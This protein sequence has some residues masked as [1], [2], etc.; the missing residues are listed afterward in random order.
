MALNSASRGR[1]RSLPQPSLRTV[2]SLP[3][4]QQ[5]PVVQDARPLPPANPPSP[6]VM[7]EQK[8]LSRQISTPVM[9]SRTGRPLPT[10]LERSS[11]LQSIRE[12]HTPP[13]VSSPSPTPQ[14]PSVVNADYGVRWSSSAPIID[15]SDTISSVK[16]LD[17]YILSHPSPQHQHPPRLTSTTS[18]NV[19]GRPLPPPPGP[20]GSAAM[21]PS[22]SLDRGVLRS[23]LGM[24]AGTGEGRLG[25][26]G[27]ERKGDDERRNDGD[28][29][30]PSEEGSISPTTRKDSQAVPVID[31]PAPS[32]HDTPVEPPH[33]NHSQVHQ[34]STPTAPHTTPQISVSPVQP[35]NDSKAP[36]IPTIA[37]PDSA[38]ACDTST[39]IPRNRCPLPVPP[40]SPS[41]GMPSIAIDVSGDDDGAGSYVPTISVSPEGNNSTAPSIAIPVIAF[42]DETDSVAQNLFLRGYP[43]PNPPPAPASS[44]PP[45]VSPSSDRSSTPLVPVGI[46]IVCG[47]R[48]VKWVWST[49]VDTSMRESRIVTWT[50]SSNSVGGVIT[51]RH[52]SLINATSPLM[53]P[54]SAN[55]S[56]TSSTSSAANAVPRSSILL[57]PPRQVQKHARKPETEAR[58]TRP[59]HTSFTDDMRSARNVISSC[60]GPSVKA[61]RCR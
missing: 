30:G 48:P 49:S 46:R 3:H 58:T 41:S 51:A 16:S 36:V 61:A 8:T 18:G 55:D 24:S 52:R 44:A 27:E 14:A 50:I 47:V 26:G 37:F 32:R 21:V 12:P 22:R 34:T 2:P 19:R 43:R 10:P 7:P 17:R 31:V 1:Q 29:Q 13:T 15:R 35:M 39:V 20:R 56:T 53:T 25:D 5:H 59:Q 23:E 60:T 54:P 28:D 11:N 4:I 38:D 33:T 57:D 6:F 40:G 45:A 42:P 9:N